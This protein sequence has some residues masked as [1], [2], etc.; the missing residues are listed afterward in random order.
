MAPMVKVEFSSCGAVLPVM[1]SSATPFTYNVILPVV[2]F[3][4]AA[5]NTHL[6]VFT[7]DL[8]LMVWSAPNIGLPKPNATLP[9]S[10]D[11]PKSCTRPPCSPSTRPIPSYQLLPSLLVW[12]VL[13][14]YSIVKSV[15]S[16]LFTTIRLGL[17]SPS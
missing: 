13:I 3:L 10:N 1:L 7:A 12:V 15:E 4:T 9:L 16:G 14:Q 6:P 8:D 2:A 5:T 11:V 17:L